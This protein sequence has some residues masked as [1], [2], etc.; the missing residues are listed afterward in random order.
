MT[1]NNGG[2]KE[3]G[4]QGSTALHAMP[5]ANAEDPIIV[6]TPRFH[7]IAHYCARAFAFVSLFLILVV[8]GG[9]LLLQSGA[10]ENTLTNRAQTLLQKA[11]GD[12]FSATV[13]NAGVR[14][15]KRGL[16]A[17]EAQNVGLNLPQNGGEVIHAQRV[18]IALK[19]LP[20]LSGQLKISHIEIYGGFIDAGLLQQTMA[21]DAAD[22]QNQTFEVADLKAVTER[23]FASIE[24][25][26]GVLSERGTRWVF[27]TDTTITGIGRSDSPDIPGATI[28]VQ[29]AEIVESDDAGLKIDAQLAYAEQDIRIDARA[30]RDAS[31]DNRMKLTARMIGLHVGKIIK[32]LTKNPRRKFRMESSV[33]IDLTAVSGAAGGNPDLRADLRISA[34]EL[35]M[36][37]IAA[38]VEPSTV[39]LAFDPQRKSI[40]IKP[41]KLKIGKSS[42]SF[43][44]GIIDLQNLPAQSKRGFAIDIIVD[45]ANVAPTDSS[46]PAAKVAMKAFARFVSEERRLYVD[47]FIVSGRAGTMFSSASIQFSDTSPEVSFVAN[48]EK[49]DTTTVKQ[50]WPYWIAKMARRW[51][52][53]NLFGGTVT[54]GK[55]SVFIPEGRMASGLPDSLNLDGEQLK[56]DFNISEARFDVA[57]DI[58]PVR[59]AMGFLTLRGKHLEL[60]IDK[61]T[62]FFPT[63]RSVKISDGLFIIDHTD[64]NPLMAELDIDV[65]GDASAV[66][67]LISYK[68]INALQQTPYK[69]GDFEGAVSSKVKVTFGLIQDQNPPSPDWNVELDL[70]GVTIGPKVDGVKVTDAKGTMHVDTETIKIDAQAD[71]NGMQANIDFTEPLDRDSKVDSI[72]VV[73]FS[74]TEA[75]RRQFAPQLNEYIK[76][77]IY[78][79]A[80]LGKNGR[81][82]IDADLTEARLILPWIGWSKGKGIKATAT[83]EMIPSETGNEV[84]TAD[85]TSTADPSD[86]GLGL[87]SVFQLHNFDIKGEGFSAKGDLDFAHGEVVKAKIGKASLSRHDRFAVNLARKGKTYVVDVAGRA[88]DLRS[89]IKHLLS[90]SEEAEI[91][92]DLSKVQL[93]VRADEA[94]GFNGQKVTGFKLDYSGQGE[95][96]LSLDLSAKTSAGGTFNAIGRHGGSGLVVTVKSNDAGNLARFTDIYPKIQGGTLDVQLVKAGNGPYIGTVDIRGFNVINDEHLKSLVSAS[97]SGGESLNQAVRRDIDVSRAQFQHAFARVDKGKGYLRVGDG[98]ARGPEVGFAFQGTVFDAKGDMNITGTFMPAYG[99]NRIFGEIPLLGVILGNGRDRGLI[100]ITF[101]LTGS[102]DDPKLQINPISLI[103]PGIFRSIFQFRNDTPVPTRAPRGNNRNVETR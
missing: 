83:F 1:E 20:L 95:T 44:G 10:V 38:Q 26:S 52:H 12:R 73:K 41:S 82:D 88:V 9:F 11:A 7:G 84:A 6:N 35:F 45:E 67:E 102:L 66:A 18:S 91:G 17:I 61:G 59:D 103:A 56:I 60:K 79:T 40:E 34:G 14:L 29:S 37:G 72:R 31:Q 65:S 64:A 70:S 74:V 46:E 90:E 28:K 62:S 15:A 43:N 30:F 96:I 77:T 48:I 89:S 8:V 78:L 4:Q 54:D 50:L 87:P 80:K 51:V 22:T 53:Q 33:E 25:L 99:L 63:G 85:S 2:H 27:L 58:P 16:V 19:I 24:T 101:R 76:G 81:Q 94:H 93:K 13:S 71:L 55:I 57:G 49:M 42:Y 68:P 36:D 23:T 92:Q 47:D 75:D 97:P 100:G 86:K 39:N 5:S 3:H 32:E 69:A 98:I 21:A